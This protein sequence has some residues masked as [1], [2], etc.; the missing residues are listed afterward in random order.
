MLGYRKNVSLIPKRL[1]CHHRH[2]YH[3]LLVVKVL[4]FKASLHVRNSCDLLYDFFFII[5]STRTIAEVK[6]DVDLCFQ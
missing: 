3:Y 6:I 2:H 5:I 1:H 4:T